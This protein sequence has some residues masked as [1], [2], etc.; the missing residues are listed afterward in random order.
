MIP[1]ILYTV[2]SGDSLR[3]IADRFSI[4]FRELISTNKIINPE[5]IYPGVTLIIPQVRKPPIE[6]NGI[7]YVF[8]NTDVPVLSNSMKYLTYLTPFSYIARED[9]SLFWIND[10]QAI[11]LAILNNVI[12]IMSVVNYSYYDTGTNAAHII[13]NDMTVMNEL[14]DNIISIM[15][16]K[17]YRGV[18]FD[19]D[20]ILPEDRDAYNNFLHVAGSRLNTEGFYI[21]VALMPKFIS[22]DYL[23][24]DYE[25][26]GRIV[27]FV[28]LKTYN[29]GLIEGPPA[30]I[31][32]IN[33]LRN[34]L[35]FALSII[36]REKIFIGLPL[37]AKDWIIPY[38]SGREAEIISAQTAI[39]R[40]QDNNAQIQYD[41]ISQSPFFYYSDEQGRM[42]E[43]WFEDPRSLKAKFDLVKEYGIRGIT[44]WNLLYEFIQ[45]WHLLEDNFII[46]RD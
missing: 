44:Y 31:I 14:I 9:G 17:G 29:W 28:L 4:P 30:P 13:L 39:I 42:H 22:P 10:Q 2:K 3:D 1:G 40:A 43:V 8:G 20:N 35:D 11:Q 23:A 37:Y 7:S 21:S 33:D 38:V 41:E 19:F 36:P 27:D 24:Y 16:K 45:N 32:P 15:I 6:V 46:V 5:L 25:A 34:V 18:K 12:P 26:L